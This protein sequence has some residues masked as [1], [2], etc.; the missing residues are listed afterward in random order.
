MDLIEAIKR[1]KSIRA[2]TPD[3]VPV[4]TIREILKIATHAPSSV[5]SQ[6]WEFYIITGGVLSELK[7]TYVEQ[8][9]SG[10]PPNPEVAIPKQKGSAPG[11]EG[12]YR[13][14]QVTLAKQLF[15]LLGI[16]REDKEKL[17]DWHQKA[18][19]FYDAPAVIVCVIDRVMK[20]G[21]PL[22]DIGVIAYSIALTAMGY[23]L[24]TCIMRGIVDYPDQLRKIANIPDSK[25]TIVGI[26]IGYPDTDHPANK[27]ETDREVLDKI[28]TVVT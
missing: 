19:R 3:P 26:A 15:Q 8:V 5:N 7:Q 4:Q 27:L 24:G 6:P 16:T 10:T 28:V 22:V 11:L 25:Q 12:I 13:E 20:S 14:R 17:A 1:R 18:Y 23:G 21:W 9:N 2:Y